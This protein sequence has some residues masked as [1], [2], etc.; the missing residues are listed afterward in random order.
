M[1]HT[2]DVRY[3]F[4]IT[5]G[6]SGTAYL[7]YLLGL[8]KNVSSVHEPELDYVH[9][10]RHVQYDPD[11]AKWFLTAQKLPA[12]SKI[13]VKH[14]Y[15]E[16][17]H[18]FCK[19]YLTAWLDLDGLPVP[20]IILLNRNFRQVALSMLRLGTIPGR[21]ESGLTWY[22][23]PEC[24]SCLTAL[25]DHGQLT[26]YQLCYWYCLEIEA[27]QKSHGELVRS[28]GGRVVSASIDQ[29]RTRQG[30]EELRHNLDL[31]GFTPVGLV[32]YALHRKTIVNSKETEKAAVDFSPS[33][34]ADWEA[35]VR[36]KTTRISITNDAIQSDGSQRN[37][38]P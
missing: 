31:P 36:E 15:A 18:L 30:F 26:D 5:T 17:S 38:G 35:E 2:T 25:A 19:G 33:Q 28:R 7:A 9:S 8:L 34:L 20:D 13:P 37:S 16:T 27:R 1:Q 12:M 11:V 32:A 4:T 24:P 6:R 14:I 10:L 22:L 3:I 21:T 29:L 23:G